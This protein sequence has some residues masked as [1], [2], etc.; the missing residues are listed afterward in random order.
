MRPAGA[1]S[2]TGLDSVTTARRYEV[3]RWSVSWAS[4][5]ASSRI[6]PG[7]SRPG[8]PPR[9][10][11]LPSGHSAPS[12]TCSTFTGISSRS[13]RSRSPA[14]RDRQTAVP[15]GDGRRG[16]PDS[17]VPPDV[18]EVGRAQEL[19]AHL[20]CTVEAPGL[21]RQLARGAARSNLQ[22][23][24]ARA[25]DAA[26]GFGV[27]TSPS[28]RSRSR[29]AAGRHSGTVWERKLGRACD[30]ASHCWCSSVTSLRFQGSS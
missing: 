6:I 22:A 15:R 16:E 10:I 26:N 23:A 1:G 2:R 12:A 24:V 3:A 5:M 27:P 13:T 4:S 21:D 18:E 8:L 25:E 9:G 20:V 17:R 28:R 30:E 14:P 11:V 19:V 29:C 7:L